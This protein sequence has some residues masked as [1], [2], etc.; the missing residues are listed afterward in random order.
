M[1]DVL[2][3][4]ATIRGTLA[5][6]A[7][8][9]FA[10]RAGSLTDAPMCSGGYD[11]W[12]VYDGSAWRL[13][14]ASDY[15]GNAQVLSLKVNG[16]ALIDS[17]QNVKANEIWTGG[18]IRIN[19]L[20]DGTYRNLTASALTANKLP[21]ASTG[22]LL[23]D[24]AVSEDAVYVRSS[25]PLS[26]DNTPLRVAPTA[27]Q[28]TLGMDV[29]AGNAA[30]NVAYT[31]G[32]VR[33]L[34]G[35]NSDAESGA[36]AGSNW[37]LRAFSDAGTLI[38]TPMQIARVAGGAMILSR[39]VVVAK[40]VSQWASELV[41]SGRYVKIT[42]TTVGPSATAKASLLNGGV[43][44]GGFAAVTDPANRWNAVGAKN[45]VELEGVVSS[46]ANQV[47][48]FELY[49]NGAVSATLTVPARTYG[50]ATPWRLVIK[51]T[52]RVAGSSGTVRV[53]LRFYATADNTNSAASCYAMD[54]ML[55]G[56][57]L[58]ASHT[59][60]VVCTIPNNA[61]NQITCQDAEKVG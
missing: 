49:R 4:L 33:W 57:D 24:S 50:T 16:V 58:T 18:A 20:G 51:Q 7:V 2:I 38:D 45:K 43:A 14:V 15:A 59:W 53:L 23:A 26:I 46:A 1:A 30:V 27:G 25:K 5:A 8:D 10:G 35:K 22:G 9:L 34:W 60:D 21:K 11:R 12:G 55:P 47:L 54:T 41:T 31:A 36:D 17:A 29:A 13:G 48:V 39:P 19:A 37:F 28:A 56:I 61:S 44:A 40:Q 42:D 52:V 3:R 6:F 32:S